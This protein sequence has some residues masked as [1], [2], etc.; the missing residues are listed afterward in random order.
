MAQ[1][2]YR[3]N[4]SAATF[5]MTIADGGRTVI[6]PGPDQNFDRRVDPEGAQKDAGIPQALYMENVMPTTNGYQSVG[7]LKP[8]IPI[9]AAGAYILGV[10]PV[11]SVAG[12]ILYRN[13]IFQSESGNYTCGQFGTDTITFVGTPLALGDTLSSATLRG[14]G[15]V[16]ADGSREIYEAAGNTGGLLL[17]NVSASVTPLGFFNT[18]AIRQI[19]S[20]A[21]Y[22]IAVSYDGRIYWSSLTTALDFTA[23]LVSGAGSIIPTD[24]IGRTIEATVASDGFYIYA[25]ISSVFVQYTGNAR[26]PFKFSV[27][28]NCSGVREQFPQR[29][30]NTAGGINISGN[31]IVEKDNSIKFAQR[32]S[33]DHLDPAVSNFLANEST[34]ALLDYTTNLLTQEVSSTKCPAV[35]IWKERYAV[36][37]INDDV[38]DFTSQYTH[39]LIYDLA[40]RRMGKL[41]IRHK[42]TVISDLYGLGFVESDIKLIRYLQLDIYNEKPSFVPNIFE[43]AQGALLLGKFQYDRSRMLQ[44]EEIEIE[45]PQNTAIIPSPNFSCVLIP[46]MDGRTFDAPEPLTPTS[47]SG[48]LVT[49]NTHRTARNHS[50]FIKGAFSVNTVQ[51]KFVPRGDR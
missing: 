46:S 6:V 26:Y 21:N 43:P 37:S 28:K 44:M 38:G 4:L 9:A 11:F 13:T 39:A 45:G 32:D 27:V 15:Y 25:D 23:S 19:L 12:G 42:F 31:L 36:I 7:Y 18:A 10:F 14:K 33:A 48:G 34:Q 8:T 3:A 47:I 35:V 29:G 2:P 50:V 20:F 16:Y 24:L 51:L 1:I 40:T 49:Y 30:K 17:S 5:P 41:K 22:L